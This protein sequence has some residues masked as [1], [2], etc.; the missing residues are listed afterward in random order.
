[1]T[2]WRRRTSVVLGVLALMILAAASRA[3]K[4]QRI[5]AGESAIT[6]SS[7]RA[8]APFAAEA[9]RPQGV[10]API[11]PKPRQVVYAS[12][13]L[14]EAWQPPIGIPRPDFGITQ[15]APLPPEPWT[16]PTDGFF[17][18]DGSARGATDEL[19]PLGTPARPRLSIPQDLPPGA[20]VELHG[21]YDHPQS[22]PR[23]LHL[24]GTAGNPVFIRGASSS[25]RPV[26]RRNWE[27]TGTYYILENLEFAPM[28]DQ[29]TTGSLVVLSPTSHMA[30]RHSELHG[31]KEDGGMGIENWNNGASR[32]D[33]IVVWHNSFH[34]NGDVNASFDQDVEGI[35]VGSYQSYVWV[36]DNELARNS[37]DGIQI[38]GS[39]GLKELT[40]HIYVGRNVSHHNKQGGFWVKQAVDV[41]FSENLAYSH[42]P[43]NSSMGH[44]LGGQYGPERVWWIYNHAHDCEY[45][46]ALMSD[47]ND[48]LVTHQFFIGNVIHN[49]HHTTLQSQSDNAWAPSAIMMAGGYE[50]YVINNTIYDVD[51]GINSPSPFGSLEI[52]NNIVAN[53]T[54]PNRCQVDIDFAALAAHTKVQHNLFFPDPRAAW[55]EPEVVHFTPALITLTQT[56]DEAPI[57]V[58]PQAD[59]FRLR[60]DSPAIGKGE[61]HAVYATFEKL[62]GIDIKR[63]ADGRLRDSGSLGAYEPVAANGQSHP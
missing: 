40:H 33:N 30:L 38:N 31:T 12:D 60:R 37:G 36:V 9:P 41:I 27:V 25:A 7:H 44:C 2:V 32:S 43:G 20:V 58:D 16:A 57:F 1:M 55:G 63:D 28:P 34:D 23:T 29:S 13:P 10:V 4:S 52:V 21:V 14:A 50:R 35:H 19:N 18:V 3:S 45:G 8:V 61:A 42:R 62:Y 17:Y 11:S 6:A 46:I 53:V 15:T 22:S 56:V 26:I 51:A 24:Q 49:I 47:W 54:D 48:G 39:E 5:A 59:N